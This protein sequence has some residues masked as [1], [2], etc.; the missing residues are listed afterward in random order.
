MRKPTDIQR[1]ILSVLSDQPLS[2]EQIAH[3]ATLLP[4]RGLATALIALW[5][6]GWVTSP[7]T[8]PLT[9]TITQTGRDALN[10]I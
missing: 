8:C 6:R 4:Q 1:K 10:L 9:Y 2:G 5:K 3:A 7:S